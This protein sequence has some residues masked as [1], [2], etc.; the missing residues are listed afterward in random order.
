MSGEYCRC[1]LSLKYMKVDGNSAIVE[2]T[3]PRVLQ[4]SPSALLVFYRGVLGS[5]KIVLGRNVDTI[6]DDVKRF[7][8]FRSFTCVEPWTGE[9]SRVW[10]EG[11]VGHLLTIK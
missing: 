4:P 3:L 11:F 2:A 7:S 5:L 9:Q 6:F 1:S 10:Y 8:Y